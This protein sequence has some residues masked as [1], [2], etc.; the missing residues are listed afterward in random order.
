MI[1]KF[2]T[3]LPSFLIACF[4]LA[5][6]VIYVRIRKRQLGEEKLDSISW[7][8]NSHESQFLGFLL[9]LGVAPI[10]EEILFRFPLILLY[11]E[12]SGAWM[13]II[14]SSVVFG[15]FHLQNIRFHQGVMLADETDTDSIKAETAKMGA[16]Q[17]EEVRRRTVIQAIFCVGMGC[18]YGYIAVNT[19]SLWMSIAIH[20]AWNAIAILILPTIVVLFVILLA[21]I[22]GCF[23]WVFGKQPSRR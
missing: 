15:A 16:E 1:E 17:P 3:F 4:V 11:D 13:G 19:Q 14:I 6:C 5:G 23:R 9:L 21:L 8:K 12:V 10:G 18:L 7:A 20:A 2:Y 22:D